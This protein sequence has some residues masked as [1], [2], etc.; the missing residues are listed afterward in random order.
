MAEMRE[1]LEELIHRVN[2]RKLPGAAP[3]VPE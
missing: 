3:R 1:L 2:D